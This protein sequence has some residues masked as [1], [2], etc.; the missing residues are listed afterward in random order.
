MKLVIQR[1]SSA[2]VSVSGQLLG[3][4][5]LGLLVYIGF[6]VGDSHNQIDK[7]VHK[8]SHLRIFPDSDSKFNLSVLD[9]H[10]KILVI[11]QFTLYSQLKGFRPSFFHALNPEQAKC[12]YHLFIEHLTHTQIPVQ[13]GKFG[14]HMLVESVNDGPV[15]IIL[16]I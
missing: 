13:S 2:S 7:A 12:L 5:S 15:T 16:E 1:V 11:P 3:K 10:G 8:L 6:G 9:V 14:A 4:I